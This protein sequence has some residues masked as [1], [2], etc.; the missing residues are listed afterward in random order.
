[1]GCVGTGTAGRRWRL[2]EQVPPGRADSASRPRATTVR[3]GGIQRILCAR[4]GSWEHPS[5]R[6]FRATVHGPA[7]LL[8]PRDVPAEGPWAPPSLSACA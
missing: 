7:S 2:G 3:E 8:P 1:M 5:R 4:G 6:V